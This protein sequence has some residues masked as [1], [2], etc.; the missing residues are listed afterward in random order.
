MTEG[1]GRWLLLTEIQCLALFV[2]YFSSY[3]E[4]TV[5]VL[6]S[7]E[8]MPQEEKKLPIAKGLL[9]LG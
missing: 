7:G 6:H 4:F 9:N 3:F 2:N 8:N 1:R 5:V